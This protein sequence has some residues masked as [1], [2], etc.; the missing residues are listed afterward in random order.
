MR[1]YIHCSIIHSNC[2]SCN[3]FSL[4]KTVRATTLIFHVL[5]FTEISSFTSIQYALQSYSSSI[6]CFRHFI[7]YGKISATLSL[8]ITPTILGHFLNIYYTYYIHIHTI[9]YMLGTLI[10]LSFFLK[11]SPIYHI[12]ILIYFIEKIFFRC[13]FQLCNFLSYL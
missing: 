6:L 2:T 7:K 8:K 1:P 13:L 5:Q 4:E 9:Q 3:R 10:P 11:H 12:F